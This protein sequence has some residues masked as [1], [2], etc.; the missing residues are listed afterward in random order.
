MHASKK[1]IYIE[2]KTTHASDE[3]KDECFK[4]PAKKKKKSYENLITQRH[5]NIK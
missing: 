2:G 3:N 5:I 1:K 4:S